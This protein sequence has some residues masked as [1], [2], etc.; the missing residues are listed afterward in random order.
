MLCKNLLYLYCDQSDQNFWPGKL[1]HLQVNVIYHHIVL[2]S[3][4]EDYF[5]YIDLMIF[6]RYFPKIYVYVTFE[7]SKIKY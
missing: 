1:T 6:W 3:S 2:E 5:N 7:Y 4:R